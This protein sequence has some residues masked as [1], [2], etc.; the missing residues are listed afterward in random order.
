MDSLGDRMKSYEHVN[1]FYLT[2]RTPCIIRVDGKCFKTFTKG[3]PLYSSWLGQAMINGAK[4]FMDETHCRFAYR[5]SDEI[6]FL[7]TDYEKFETQPWVGKNLQKMV[8][9][10]ASIVTGGFN[11]SFGG[12]KRAAFDARAFTLPKEE[13]CNYFIWRQRDAIRN[14]ILSTAQAYIGKRQCFGKSCEQ[15][16]EEL[17][18]SWKVNWD[19]DVEACYQRGECLLDDIWDL[20]IP[21]FSENRDYVDRFVYAVIEQE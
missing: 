14:S 2:R 5:Q 12:G 1:R 11:K 10:T 18:N 4:A 7:L 19:T 3:L 17:K 20:K 21:I 6:S 16:K 9:L 8:S 13:V 15:L